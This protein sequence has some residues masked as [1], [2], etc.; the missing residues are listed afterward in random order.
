MGDILNNLTPAELIKLQDKAFSKRAS[1]ACA[2]CG[3]VI[4]MRKDQRFCSPACRVAAARADEAALFE[5]VLLLQAAWQHE[6]EELIHE[7]SALRARVTELGG[8]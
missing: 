2:Q 1:R 8:D 6:R 5:R 7:I 3:H 4:D